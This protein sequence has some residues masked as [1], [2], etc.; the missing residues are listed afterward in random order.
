MEVWDLIDIGIEMIEEGMDVDEVVEELR[1]KYNVDWQKMNLVEEALE[2]WVRE[3]VV[4][5]E[6]RNED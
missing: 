1:V 2:E 5:R 3:N 6:E 4:L